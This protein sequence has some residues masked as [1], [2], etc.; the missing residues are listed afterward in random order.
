MPEELKPC[1]S[2]GS[3]RICLSE[4]VGRKVRIMCPDCYMNGPSDITSEAAVAAWNALPRRPIWTDEP[5]KAEG[6][7]FIKTLTGVIMVDLETDAGAPHGLAN[8]AYGIHQWAGPI[9]EP[10]EPENDEGKA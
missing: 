1:P 6:F 3:A 7:Y 10:L 5:P 2:C 9:E 4:H 8:R